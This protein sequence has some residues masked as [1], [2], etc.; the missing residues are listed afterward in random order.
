MKPRV[1]KDTRIA[2]L[3][4]WLIWCA[5]AYGVATIIFLVAGDWRTLVIGGLG[6]SVL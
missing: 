2:R 4:D 1:Y 6:A 5:I 3:K